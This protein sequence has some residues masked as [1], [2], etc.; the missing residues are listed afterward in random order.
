MVKKFKKQNKVI[1]PFLKEYFGKEV[2]KL[3]EISSEMTFMIPKEKRNVFQQFF[4]DF[5][6]KLDELEIKS[7]GI[8]ITTLE[9]VFLAVNAENRDE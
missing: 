4:Q 5:D 3:S 8:S 1:E 6:R 9:E 2:E 7:Y